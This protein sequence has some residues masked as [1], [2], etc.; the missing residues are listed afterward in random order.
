MKSLSAFIKK[1]FF[2]IIRDKKT[3]LIIFV[4][5]V[6][7]VTLFGFA[8]KVEVKD[9]EVAILDKSKD[10]L[11]IGLTK[12]LVSSKYFIKNQDL[13]SEREIEECFKDGT[14]KMVII[15]PENFSHDFY[16]QSRASIQIIADASN[17]NSATSVLSYTQSIID[18]YRKEVTKSEIKAPPFD[19]TVKMMYNPQMKDVYMFVPGVLAL[20]LMIIS[21]IMTAV[22]LTKEK[23]D[24]TYNILKI[25]PLTSPQTIIGKVIPYLII[26]LINTFII[27][28]LSVYVLDM[29]IIGNVFT[30]FIVCLTFLFTALSFGVLVSSI[31][32]SVQV[33]I[34]ISIV[35]LFMPTTLLSGFIYPIENMPLPLQVL[36]QIFP[37]K[38]F[39]EAVKSV[40]IK[41]GGFSDI[42]LQ[43]SVL[44]VMTLFYIRVSVLKYSK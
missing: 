15:I 8:I 9:I 16:N 38:W 23:E 13:T 22:S 17:M 34:T 26:S 21:S 20:V 10:E 30:L 1:E 11:S 44:V 19:V 31:S 5:P 41:G 40:M 42:W 12:K 14:V 29:V 25:S 37:A 28:V 39:I 36:C 33:A 6:M 32:N 24:G 2:H 43:L 18:D 35:G 7:L 3:L 27:I 4:M